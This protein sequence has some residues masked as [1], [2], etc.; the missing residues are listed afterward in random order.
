MLDRLQ[1]RPGARRARKRVARGPG[2]KAGKTAG[3]GTKGQGKRSAGRERPARFEGGQMPLAR[4]LPKRGFHSPSRTVFQEV[5]VGAL[6]AFGDGASVDFEAL[7]SRGLVR[8]KGGAV[9]LLGEGVVPKGLN[10][11]IARVSAGAR[12]KIEAAGGTV[13]LVE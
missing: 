4:R 6:A 8:R 10:V 12:A 1:P 13:E 2:G 7:A 5:N 11:R 9:K 3:R